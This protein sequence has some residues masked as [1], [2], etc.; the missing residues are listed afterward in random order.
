MKVNKVKEKL[1]NGEVV[2]GTQ[3]RS[4]SA[5]VAEL[6]GLC[7]FDYL[8]IENEHFTYNPETIEDMV[9]TAELADIVPIVRIPKN[10]P[11]T[12]MQHLDAG[13]LGIIIPHID[14]VEDATKAV[15]A[16]KYAPIGNRGFSNTSRASA[17]GLMPTQEY[18]IMANNE[19]MVIAMIESKEAVENL[20]GILATGIDCVHIG[21][22]DLSESYGYSG[23]QDH[24][25]VQDAIEYI[26]QTC[27]S[28]NVP[29]G[30][31]TGTVEQA[32]AIIERGIQLVSYSSDLVM[33]SKIARETLDNI[34]RGRK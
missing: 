3:I 29:I 27:K 34:D 8:F 9:R 28:K 20:E 18:L 12:I 32:N 19:V 10:D 2:I 30:W 11:E 13:V 16:A 1:K 24:K 7:G 17:F 6:F 26:I 14:T 5:H 33:L 15:R 4:R 25:E 31:P 23:E 21:Q 22:M